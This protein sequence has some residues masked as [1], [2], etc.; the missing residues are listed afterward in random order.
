[1]IVKRK[2]NLLKLL[3]SHSALGEVVLRG[4]GRAIPCF[5]NQAN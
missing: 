3:D 2:K 4:V 5:V 1:M